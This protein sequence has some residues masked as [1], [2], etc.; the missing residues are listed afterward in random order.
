MYDHLDLKV[1]YA[2]MNRRLIL[3][4]RTSR[5]FCSSELQVHKV[6]YLRHY[7]TDSDE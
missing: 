2:P 5:L 7:T 1:P 4:P 6:L 3:K